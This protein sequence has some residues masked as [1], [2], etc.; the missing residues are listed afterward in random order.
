MALID[1]SPALDTKIGSIDGQHKKLVALINGLHEAMKTG[2]GKEVVAKAIDELVDYTVVHFSN[3]EK[4]MTSYGFPGYIA[5]KKE[6]DEFTQKVRKLDE[7][8]KSG[9]LLIT[10][11]IMRFLKDW[12]TTHIQGTDQKYSPFLIGKGV[13]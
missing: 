6:H 2:M 7:D 12:L 8:F 4:L 13:S 3:E 5:H 11:E 10:I 9:K 1:W